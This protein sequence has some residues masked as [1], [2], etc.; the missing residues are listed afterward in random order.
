MR[1][2]PFPL[3]LICLVSI[4]GHCPLPTTS[5]LAWMYPDGHEL[6]SDDDYDYEKAVTTSTGSSQRCDYHPC[7]ESQTPCADL[8][9]IS[10]CLC[11]GFTLHNEAPRAPDLKSVSW[12]GSDVVAKWCEPHSYVSFYIV[13]V[14][15]EDRQTFTRDQRNGGVGEIDHISQVCVV[16]VNDAGKSDPSCLMYK[17][18]DKRPLTAGLIGGALGFLLLL[19]LAL[20]VWRCRRQRKQDSG[21]SMKNRTETE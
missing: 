15:G 2:L 16:A 7:R 4:R 18:A 13:T 19:V 5:G 20:T 6:F 12:N 3:A 1:N 21:I 17:P 11:P 8:A 10:H 9:E 14:G